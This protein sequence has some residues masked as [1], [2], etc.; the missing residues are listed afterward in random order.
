MKT[1]NAGMALLLLSAV[2]AVPAAADMPKGAVG[3]SHQGYT[4]DISRAMHEQRVTNREH[5]IVAPVTGSRYRG[6]TAPATRNERVSQSST[7]WL[8]QAAQVH[9]TVM[10]LNRGSE[11]DLALL[12]FMP[13]TD[14]R[15]NHL[16]TVIR[17][18]Q[19]ARLAEVYMGAEGKSV[20][21]P[22]ELLTPRADFAQA[23]TVSKQDALAMQQ[24][25]AKTYFAYAD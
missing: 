2:W 22:V 11:T 19:E 8:Q 5:G 24:T 14:S 18:D 10:A 23:V 12:E 1:R 21:M 4:D 3:G 16:G 25:Q 7:Y 9:N 13:V 17:I 15:G 6:L 20:A